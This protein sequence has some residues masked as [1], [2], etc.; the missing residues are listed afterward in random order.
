MT[1][2]VFLVGSEEYEEE[3]VPERTLGRAPMRERDRLGIGGRVS[4]SPGPLPNYPFFQETYLGCTGRERSVTLL[5]LGMVDVH[6][7]FRFCSM[8]KHRDEVSLRNVTGYS[9]RY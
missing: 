4:P 2:V 9:M 7:P 3:G 6:L 5:F 1:E 8:G